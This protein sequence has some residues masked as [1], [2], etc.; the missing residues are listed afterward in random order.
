MRLSHHLAIIYGDDF[1]NCLLNRGERHKKASRIAVAR[2]G[3]VFVR[4]GIVV[5]TARTAH[6]HHRRN[7]VLRDFLCLIF[8]QAVPRVS[9]KPID[10]I[11]VFGK[12][13]DDLA[14]FLHGEFQWIRASGNSARANRVCIGSIFI[15]FATKICCVID[16]KRAFFGNLYFQADSS[17]HF[18]Q[19]VHGERDGGHL[20][21]LLRLLP[22]AR[23]SF[24]KRLHFP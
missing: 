10:D 22:K 8:S 6:V 15:F 20:F 4:L 12:N 18:G 13:M 16:F 23:F 21:R 17:A 11:Y 3:S 19:A 14:S 9:A 1:V 7:H 24:L 5:I 2:C